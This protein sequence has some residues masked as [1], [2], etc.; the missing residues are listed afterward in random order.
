MKVS[1]VSD[2]RRFLRKTLSLSLFLTVF[3]SFL[4]PFALRAEPEERGEPKSLF[5]WNKEIQYQLL[6]HPDSKATFDGESFARVKE[7]TTT[8][9][10]VLNPAFLEKEGRELFHRLSL[11]AKNKIFEPSP[12]L[13]SLE[14]KVLSQDSSCKI[15]RKDRSIRK[16]LE[17]LQSSLEDSAW[18]PAWLE[19]VRGS[20][21]KKEAEVRFVQHFTKERLAT[22]EVHEVAHLID[23]EDHGDDGSPNYDRFTELNAF[24]SELAYSSNPKDVMAQALSGLIDEMDEGKAT[25]YS[26]SKVGQVLSFLNKN[27]S[28]H[29]RNQGFSCGWKNLTHLNNPDFA[30]AGKALYLE[31]HQAFA[32]LGGAANFSPSGE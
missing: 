14:K 32:S 21:T 6:L 8:H 3:L 13:V 4:F 30:E 1:F 27:L 28:S 25:D 9:F 18:A 19:A 15:P 11:Q 31:N 23:L 10:V 29:P 7:G 2:T 24:F 12:A 20:A 22:L 16:A 5:L 26:G 17:I